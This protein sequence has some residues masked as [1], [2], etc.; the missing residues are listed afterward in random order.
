VDAITELVKR[1][2]NDIIRYTQMFED[3]FVKMLFDESVRQVEIAQRKNQ[4]KL[5]Q[6]ELRITDI[7]ILF[8]KLYE[9]RTLGKMGEDRFEKLADKY[10][11]EQDDI[12]VQIADLAVIVADEHRH[13][14][15]A[16]E[17]V[18]MVQKYQQIKQLTPEILAEFIDHID[19][20][21][22]ETEGLDRIQRVDIYYRIIGKVRIPKMSAE[23]RERMM[24][25]FGRNR[26]E[27]NDDRKTVE[28]QKKRNKKA[29]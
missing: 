7:D 19:V 3:D 20:Y 1:N 5:N 6:L 12:K 26:K 22:R 25:S 8:E 11:K 28:V 18:K 14:V 9:D 13:E 24:K 21:H 10:E 23:E 27:E 4:I 17:F 15:N 16:D 29:S 2:I